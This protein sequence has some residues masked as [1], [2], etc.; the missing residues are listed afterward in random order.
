MSGAPCCA[1]MDLCEETFGFAELEATLS[2][3]PNMCEGFNDGLGRLDQ[4]FI[5]YRHAAGR[6]SI[7][8]PRG[9]RGDRQ[10]KRY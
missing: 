9:L 10:Y 1:S 2:Y 4:L 3:G 8:V 7:C 6:N 5:V